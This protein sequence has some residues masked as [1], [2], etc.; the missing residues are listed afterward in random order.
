[1]SDPDRRASHD[2]DFE[3]VE[4]RLGAILAQRT[5]RSL[6]DLDDRRPLHPSEPLTPAA[7]AVLLERATGYNIILTKRTDEVEHHKGEISLAGGAADPEDG[8]SIATALRETHEE[9]GIAPSQVRVLGTLDE[10]ITVTGFRVTPVVCVVDAGLAYRLHAPEVERILKVPLQ[11][12]RTPD[13]WFVDVRSWR[14]KTYRLRSCRFGDDII[15]GA[16]SRI[17]QNLLHVV[18]ADVL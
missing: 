9:I 12:L 10:L 3:D 13:A 1:M 2:V 5:R 11:V 6:G 8:D 16:T 15:W 17:L 14:G 4:T 7:V 18:P